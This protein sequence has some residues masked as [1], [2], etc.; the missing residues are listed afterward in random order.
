MSYLHRS[1]NATRAP[2]FT[3]G[4]APG[5]FPDRG[6]WICAGPVSLDT[7]EDGAARA[8]LTRAVSLPVESDVVSVDPDEDPG[9]ES[10]HNEDDQHDEARQHATAH[11]ARMCV[12][13]SEVCVHES[14]H[15]EDDQHDEARQHA[16]AHA[17]REVR[18]CE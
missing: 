11:A 1:R 9:H 6:P 18:V 7:L 3:T 14:A 17:A 15:N 13:V 16:T 2:R 12:C 10:A 4:P 5:T 8:E